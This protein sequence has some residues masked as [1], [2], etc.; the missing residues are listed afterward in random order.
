MQFRL[1]ALVKTC[2]H[3]AG[4]NPISY[5]LAFFANQPL[6][7]IAKK[8]GDLHIVVSALAKMHHARLAV[9]KAGRAQAFYGGRLRPPKAHVAKVIHP[10]HGVAR[11]VWRV[12]RGRDFFVRTVGHLLGKLGVDLRGRGL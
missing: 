5:V 12:K 6:A 7:Q 3:V 4:Y 11:C 2:N 9:G 8:L 10:W 1:G